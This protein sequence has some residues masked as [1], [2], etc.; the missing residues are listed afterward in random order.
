MLAITYKNI[1]TLPRT[2]NTSN[3]KKNLVFI[4]LLNIINPTKPK[5]I[6]TIKKYK[7]TN[8]HP[9]I[10]T[11]NHKITTITITNKINISLKKN[12][13]ITKTKLKK[14]P[15]KKLYQNIQNYSIYAHI[16]PKHKIH[17]IQT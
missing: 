1:N 3:I 9:I 15:N 16:A 4:G 13:T 6:K 10:I 14:I 2:I 17:I 7:N 5:I 12:K 8:I 11:K